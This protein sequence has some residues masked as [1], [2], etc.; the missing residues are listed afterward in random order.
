M[1]AK[2]FLYVATY[3]AAFGFGLE[4]GYV[5]GSSWNL[6][7][8]GAGQMFLGGFFMNVI[9]TMVISIHVRNIFSVMLEEFK[10]IQDT[11]YWLLICSEVSV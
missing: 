1:V 8:N 9:V 3:H 6:P 7:F 4:S 2:F 5:E 11:T 10:V